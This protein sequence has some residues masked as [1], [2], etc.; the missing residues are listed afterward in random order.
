MQSLFVPALS[1][2]GVLPNPL[3]AFQGSAATPYS[4]LYENVM[5]DRLVEEQQHS[6]QLQ[7][8]LQAVQASRDQ[9]AAAAASELAAAQ[10][11][12][13]QLEQEATEKLSQADAAAAEAEGQ[14]DD[15][16]HELEEAKDAV[17]VLTLVTVRLPLS[18]PW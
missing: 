2:Q 11:A 4:M 18:C 17:K 15:L 14:L 16:A 3:L 5:Q 9:A 10:Q 1:Y 6:K 7:S 12:L 8:Q 13:H